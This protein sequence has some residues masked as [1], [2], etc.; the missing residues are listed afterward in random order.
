M[1]YLIDTDVMIDFFKHKDPDKSPIVSL[2]KQG[3][4]ALSALTI[5]EL[6]SGWTNKQAD[7]LMP[8]L[9]ALCSVVPVSREIA[10]Q[11]GIWRGEY[12]NKGLSLATVDTVI[13]ATAYLNN[14]PLLTNNVKDYPMPELTALI[15]ARATLAPAGL[16]LGSPWWTE[17]RWR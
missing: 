1:T 4:I 13:A 8:R 14:Y 9:Y 11:A 12:K 16:P 15:T 3:T 7:F 10:E 5:T 2:S 6:R 17:R